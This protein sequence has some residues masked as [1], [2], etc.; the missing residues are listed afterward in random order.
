MVKNSTIKQ[1]I[2][3]QKMEAEEKKDLMREQK[4]LRNRNRIIDS[5]LEENHRRM[6]VERQVAQLEK[7]EYELIQRL[8]HTSNIQKS[9]YE[10]LES[11]LHGESP[12]QLDQ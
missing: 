9:A 4:R 7:V 6:E 5:I 10:D 12:E 2:R 3:Q 8:Q 11:A 1:A